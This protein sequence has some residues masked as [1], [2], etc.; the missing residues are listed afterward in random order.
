MTAPPKWF[1]VPSHIDRFMF[2]WRYGEIKFMV[3]RMKEKRMADEAQA[4]GV[5]L[6]RYIADEEENKRYIDWF[7][8]NNDEYQKECAEFNR[9][10]EQRLCE[11]ICRLLE[12]EA[13]EQGASASTTESRLILFSFSSAV[14][15]WSGV[16]AVAVNALDNFLPAAP[17][18]PVV[19]FVE[20]VSTDNRRV[21][22]IP[23]PIDPPSPLKRL[24]ESTRTRA[25]DEPP[26]L[27]LVDEQERYIGGDDLENDTELGGTGRR[28]YSDPALQSWAAHRDAFLATLLWRDGRGNLAADLCSACGHRPATTRCQDCFMSP[29]TCDECCVSAH[30]CDPLHWVERWT[31]SYF[32][33]SSL[34]SCGLRVQLGHDGIGTCSR[35]RPA[36]DDFVIMDRNGI[37]EV[38]VDYCGCYHTTDADHLQ[39]LKAGWYPG[40]TDSPRTCATL[41]CLNLFQTLSLHGKTTAYDFYSSLETLTN[42]VGVKPPDRYR[43]FLRISRQY[44]HL[45]LLKRAGRGHDRFGVMGTGPGELALR[46]PACPRPGVNLPADWEKV[47]AEDRFLYMQHIAM[48]A[49]FR[50]KRRLV[51]SWARDPGLG[52]G[53]AY[54]LEPAAWPQLITQTTNFRAGY[55]ATGVGMGV[56]ARHEL[57]LPTAV[58]DLQRGERY[59]NMDYIFASFLRHLIGLLWIIVSYDIA[60]QW[61]KNLRERLE[62]L[63][64]DMRFA[65]LWRL[66]E[67]ARFAIPKMHIKGHIVLCQLLFAWGLL[68]GGA[69]TDGEGVERTWSWVGGVAASTRASGPGSRADQLDDHMSFWNWTKI[70]RM[71]A[72]LRRRRDKAAYELGRQE[73][74][75]DAFCAQQA[76]KVPEWQEAIAK[77]E[78]DPTQPNP[79]ESKQDNGLTE[80]DVRNRFEEEEAKEAASGVIPPHEIG[81]AEFMTVLLD[82][83]AEQRRVHAL[84]SLKR[85]NTSSQKINLRRLRRGLN[86]SIARIRTLQAVY[87]PAAIC[88]LASLNLA[89]DTVAE[90]VPLLPPSALAESTRSAGGC[91]DGLVELERQLRDAQCRS[92]LAAL[93]LQ[94]HVKQRLLAYKRHHSRNQGANTRSR[95]LVARNENKILLRADKYQAARRALVAIDGGDS[96]KTTWPVLLK[97]HI[98]CMDDSDVVT[99]E[100]PADRPDVF[101]SAPVAGRSTR[102]SGQPS[103]E[104]RRVISWIWRFTGSAGTD[105]EMQD[106]LHVEWSKASARVRRWREEVRLLDEEWRRLSVSFL[107]EEQNWVERAKAVA[108]G[109]IEV[110]L[111]E[112]LIAYATKHA[113]MFRDLARRAE[114]IRT[115]APLRKGQRRPR[116]TIHIDPLPDETGAD[117]LDPLHGGVATEATTGS[118]MDDEDVEFADEV[119]DEDVDVHGNASDDDEDF[120]MDGDGY[121]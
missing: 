41:A 75:F 72:L 22:S 39:L 96:T 101:G 52:T 36:R 113:D 57:I 2:V 47:S 98:R 104:T 20:R 32:A 55:A 46:C 45:L 33:R 78:A 87:M 12:K 23:V 53:W 43:V 94:L 118:G 8:A 14:V 24:R 38:A 27:M 1:K 54:M 60:C 88:Y 50:L 89:Q 115:A 71:A 74:S 92:A 108:V 7:F 18:A 51:S 102:P 9:K 37:H 119:I 93:R 10:A 85:S 49:C 77:F 19:T 4:K 59:A 40:T 21:Q 121:D 103:G 73:E 111:A 35:P 65:A 86:K 84:A 58:G 106:A 105:A 13:A 91:R 16:D 68:F 107:Y 31:G 97:E 26:P 64:A 15:V 62:K 67:L 95:A 80:R 110:G 81:P 117:E 6:E 5:P 109:E 42:A 76:D 112:G 17:N 120:I 3:N 11:N 61:K 114:V 79:Y 100:P 30:A 83:E 44:R 48:D 34:R 63:P 66:I 116:E 99:F 70:I 69:Q 56:C 90:L 28:V 29:L 25:P 82:V